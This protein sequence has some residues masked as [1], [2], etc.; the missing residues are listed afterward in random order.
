[1]SNNSGS[2]L[3]K[4]ISNLP[5]E[6]VIVNLTQ[7]VVSAQK[8]LDTYSLSREI[9]YKEKKYDK[10]FGLS[11]TWYTIP[12]VT[13]DLKL[14]FHFNDAGQIETEMVDAEYM[15]KS[16]FDVKA[17]SSLQTRIV[18]I[19]NEIKNLSLQNDDSIMKIVGCNQKLLELYDEATSPFIVIE[20]RPFSRT[21][22]NDGL[23]YVS[24]IDINSTTAERELLALIIIRDSVGEIENFLRPSE[25]LISGNLPNP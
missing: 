4:M 17:T 1:M 22:Y 20:Y 25:S 8:T 6:D 10:R 16:N 3:T 12:E 11:A 7:S 13:L 2:K 14:A 21:G 24:L 19:P 18:P 5:V 9:E 15:S 23:W